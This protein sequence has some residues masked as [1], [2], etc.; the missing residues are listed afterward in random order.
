[1]RFITLSGAVLISMVPTSQAQEKPVVGY[2]SVFES[3]QPFADEPLQDWYQANQRVHQIGGWRAYMQEAM[4]AKQTTSKTNQ[5][6][7]LPA[8][9]SHSQSS[10]QT[11]SKQGGEK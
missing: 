5:S 3:Y 9:S 10:S 6:Q 7:T 11:H 4:Q 2:Q 1:M 8:G